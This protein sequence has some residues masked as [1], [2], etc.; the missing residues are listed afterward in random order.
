MGS[1]PHVRIVG[2]AGAVS[3]AVVSFIRTDQVGFKVPVAHTQETRVWSLLPAPPGDAAR[4]R[5]VW[6]LVHSHRSK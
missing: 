3:S 2:S 5:E 6:N 1:S 4:E